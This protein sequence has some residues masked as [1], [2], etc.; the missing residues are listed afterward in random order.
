MPL[1]LSP[2]LR[3]IPP[4]AAAPIATPDP[5]PIAMDAAF[6]RSFRHC[7]RHLRRDPPDCCR[8]V[9]AVSYRSSKRVAY[10][11][12]DPRATGAAP[13]VLGLRHDRSTWSSRR[14]GAMELS[15]LPALANR[16]GLITGATGTGKTVTLQTMAE[17]FSRIGVPVFM[18]DVKGDLSGLGAAGGGNAQGRR[19][20]RGSSASSFARKRAPSFSG[21][22]SA[23]ADT[24]CA[25]RSPISG[26]CCSRGCSIS[27]RSKKAC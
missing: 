23:D 11:G 26:R 25:R 21:T 14:A 1:T 13:I 8:R 12:R 3:A 9:R 27:T 24:R 7:G 19:S 10:F 6:G 22:Y 16:H 17:Q 2:R 5:D 4:S 15:L 18:A 20:A